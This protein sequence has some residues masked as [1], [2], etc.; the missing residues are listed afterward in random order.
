MFQLE[1]SLND[2]D[3]RSALFEC[4]ENI[5]SLAIFLSVCRVLYGLCTEEYSTSFNGV[6]PINIIDGFAALTLFFC[7]FIIPILLLVNALIILIIDLPKQLIAI[8]KKSGVNNIVIECMVV[9]MVLLLIHP[10]FWSTPW[11]YLAAYDIC[12]F[13]AWRVIT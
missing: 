1:S 6:A 12:W 2:G 11:L 13:F 8:W 3:R 10:F 7:V 5:L 9:F 4:F